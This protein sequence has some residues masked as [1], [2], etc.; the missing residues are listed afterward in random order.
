ML[1]TMENQEPAR[2]QEPGP[3][4]KLCRGRPAERQ[5]PEPTP[6]T[7]ESIARPLMAGPAKAQDDWDYLNK[8]R[9][10]K[11]RNSHECDA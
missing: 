8:H 5:W 10:R 6:E 2:D 3:S 4:Q 11:N 1:W 9:S 7:H